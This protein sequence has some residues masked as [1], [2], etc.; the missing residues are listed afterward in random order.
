MSARL[1][2]SVSWAEDASRET[3]T[4]GV[5]RLD[6]MLGGGLPR[7]SA[8]LLCGSPFTGK[9]VLWKIAL[10]AGL[11]EGTPAIVLLT[12]RTAQRVRRALTRLD[13]GYPGYE[14]RGLVWY[15]DTYSRGA[16]AD[17]PLLQTHY[18][19]GANQLDAMSAA[20]DRAREAVRAAGHEEHRFVIASLSTLL[21][22]NGT[23]DML[24]FLHCTLGKAE[25]AGAVSLVAL[26]EDAHPPSEVAYIRHVVDDAIELKNEG[27]ERLLRVEGAHG[28]RR[29]WIEYEWSETG[30]EITGS[31]GATR[32]R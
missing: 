20:L 12:D 13:E 6:E 25:A 10:L 19:D 2:P 21:L 1:S 8:T 22:A 17:E 29:R 11:R 3:R 23:R 32:I 16:G 27:S 7:P 28:E 15:V 9:S 5:R 18:V 26:E 4:T 31:I 14:T 30:F 24:P